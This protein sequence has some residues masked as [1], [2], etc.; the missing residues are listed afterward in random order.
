MP[1]QVENELSDKARALWLK[2]LSALEQRN[3]PYAI[4][5]IQAVLKE[6]PGFLD[7]R[8]MLRKAEIATAKGKK[9]F[10]SGLSGL[11]TKGG[12]NVKKDPIAA[13]EAAEKALESDPHNVQ[14]NNL[15]K[16][17]AKAAGYPEIAAFALQTI[18]DGN[19]KDTKVLHE[20]GEHYLA[21]GEAE[22]AVAVYTRIIELNPADLAAIKRSKDA[23]ATASMKSG[24]WNEAKSYRDLIKDKEQALSLEQKA[25]VVRSVETID[26]Q[27]GEAYTAWETDST[28][29]DTCR[30]VAKLWEERYELQGDD[31]SIDGAVYFYSQADQ[32]AGGSDPH[33]ARKLSDLKL[34]K[35]N[36][37]IAGLE[38]WFAEGGSQH[39]DAPTYQAELDALRQERA[40]ARIGEARKRVERNPTDL[41]LR[42]EL[43]EQLLAAGQFNEAIPELQRA[44]QNPSTRLR[45][46]S[47]LGQCFVQKGM[48]DM[49]AA[50]F[51]T[52]ASE[53][54]GMDTVKKETIYNLGLVYEKMG[55]TEDHI[56]CMKEIMEADYGYR[57]VARRVEASYGQ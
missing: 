3:H 40:S 5:L 10:L 41:Q 19:P 47:L 4:S 25:R 15:L 39:E 35:L 56:Q 38:K 44:R 28:S 32:L 33:V 43:G 17:A 7:G 8:K 6:F 45:A 12:G 20:L 18:I 13:M 23:S 53:M 51:K 9:S 57:D 37:R 24:G 29:L 46:M 27:L 22:R 16:E 31:E 49:A 26:Q 30:R 11:S 1:I 50:Q 48:L 42:F 54:V 52:A 55:R 2:A 14:A 34:K 36:S 21:M